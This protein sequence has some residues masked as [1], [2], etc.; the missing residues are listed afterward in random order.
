[1]QVSLY[2]AKSSVHKSLRNAAINLFV[3]YLFMINNYTC[4]SICSTSSSYK[5]YKKCAFTPFFNLWSGPEFYR[6]GPGFS[7]TRGCPLEVSALAVILPHTCQSLQSP[8]RWWN[9]AVCQCEA[10]CPTVLDVF[11]APVIF[12]ALL[13]VPW[14]TFVIRIL[15]WMENNTSNCEGN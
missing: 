3:N 15:A 11:T 10:C 6:V 5:I 14:I 13:C 2:I 4:R 7:V 1:M 9:T 8:M 12:V